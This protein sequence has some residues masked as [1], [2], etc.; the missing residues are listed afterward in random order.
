VG[1]LLPP[2]TPTP[3]ESALLDPAGGPRFGSEIELGGRILANVWNLVADNPDQLRVD[4]ETLFPRTD[5]FLPP[6]VSHIGR[7]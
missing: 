1:W 4:I 2:G 3:E 5:A 7:G 6:G